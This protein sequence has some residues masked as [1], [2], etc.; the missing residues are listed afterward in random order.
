MNFKLNIIGWNLP[1]KINFTFP[2]E[3][4]TWD[5]SSIVRLLKWCQLQLLKH[6]SPHCMIDKNWPNLS[7][8]F[9]FPYCKAMASVH[10]YNKYLFIFC[11]SAAFEEKL[12]DHSNIAHSKQM[13]KL[14]LVRLP[15]KATKWDRKGAARHH[16]RI[17]KYNVLSKKQ[18][19]SFL[20]EQFLHLY[21]VESKHF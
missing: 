16:P 17:S 20:P 2:W 1:V 7:I 19:F 5:S 6:C 13:Y 12:V 3:Q 8:K 11:Q 9:S 4:D 15:L 18:F 10:L 21:L 14:L